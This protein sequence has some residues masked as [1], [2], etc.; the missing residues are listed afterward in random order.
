MSICAGIRADG[1]RCKAQA[2]RDSEWCFN[3]HPNYEGARKRRASKG[4]KRGGRGRP[5]AELA[6]LRDRL[7]SLGEDVLEGSIDRSNAAV[8]GQ[9]WNIAIGA[10]RVAL[11][12]KEVEELE[13]RLAE[14]EAALEARQRERNYGYSG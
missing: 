3:H 7:I 2:I 10:I 5:Q 6:A 8:A 4:G 9:L 1:S 14:L 12:A 11:K 13:E